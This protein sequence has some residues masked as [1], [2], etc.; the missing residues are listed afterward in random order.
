ME[1]LG[2]E[3]GPIEIG[4]FLTNLLFLVTLILFLFIPPLKKIKIRNFFYDGFV[5]D[6]I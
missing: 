3:L 5:L 1:N 2:V 4:A 6:P